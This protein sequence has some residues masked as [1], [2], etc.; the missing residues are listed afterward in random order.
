MAKKA[1]KKASS[2]KSSPT[3]R[4]LGE[5]VLLKRLEAEST[6]AGGIVL[7]GLCRPELIERAVYPTLDHVLPHLGAEGGAK[8]GELLS[9]QQGPG[10]L[11]GIVSEKVS[12]D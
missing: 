12:L 11:V 1:A 9:P 8:L 7:P 3:I 5:K 2:K 10:H 4:P 6:T